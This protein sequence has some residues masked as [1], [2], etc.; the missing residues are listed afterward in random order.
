[1]GK[2]KQEII[3]DIANHFAGTPYSNC[4]E[5]ITADVENRLFGNHK[6]SK[7]NGH[8]IYR[9][10]ASHTIARDVEQRFLDKGMD[11]GCGGGD[12][13]S[14]IVYAYKKTSATNQ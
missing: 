6:V 13:S 10:A 2:T 14:K 11:G 12:E 8:W 9:P 4:Y 7:K 5:G 1:M 3:N